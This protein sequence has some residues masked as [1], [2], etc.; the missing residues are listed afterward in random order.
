LKLEHW[1][2]RVASFPS[3]TSASVFSRVNKCC[4]IANSLHSSGMPARRRPSTSR[5]E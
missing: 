4:E 1:R 5:S 3:A 2:L